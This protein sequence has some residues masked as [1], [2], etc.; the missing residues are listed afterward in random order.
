M[1]LHAR[2]SKSQDTHSGLRG[3]IRTQFASKSA[4]A[5]R[6]KGQALLV[7]QQEHRV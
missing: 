3:R 1:N 5:M 2:P 6:Q 4:F 7:H